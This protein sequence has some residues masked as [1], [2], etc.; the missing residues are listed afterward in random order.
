MLPATVGLDS[1]RFLAFVPMAPT[2]ASVWMDAVVGATSF[3]AES[4]LEAAGVV[5]AENDVLRWLAGLAGLPAGAGGCFMSG[6]SIGNLSALA[7]AREQMPVGRV[8]AVADTAHASVHNALHLLGLPVLVVPTGAS[9]RLTGALV[10]GVA[11]VAGAARVGVIVAA[12]G[13]TNSGTID[14]L[15]SLADA[16]DELGAWLHVD[17][18]YGGAA[19]LLPELRD[20]F[21]GIERADS[22]IIDPHKWLFSTSGSCALLFRDPRRAAAVHT[23]HGPYLDVL[24]VGE[25]WNPSDYGFQLTR[26]ATGMPLWFSLAVNGTDR[27]TA[28]VRKGVQLAGYAADQLAARRPVVELVAPPE[29][30]VVLFRRHGWGAAEWAR[31][32]ADLLER[33]VAFVAP[34]TWRGE[35]VGRLVFLHPRTTD[36]IVDEVVAS[37][38]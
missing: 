28:A 13:S 15:A 5:A 33:G 18:A 12:A 9:G 21:A 11:G 14:D 34:S 37:L 38:T 22:L 24:R 16:S 3:S 29:L 20:R 32:A 27:Y 23:Q 35:P 31:W 30:S 1:E 10:R 36:A 4:W 17:A 25:T 6:G 26:R 7:V 2:A 19:L 8:V